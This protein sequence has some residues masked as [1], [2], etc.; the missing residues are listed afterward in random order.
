MNPTTNTEAGAVADV[1]AIARGLTIRPTLALTRWPDGQS[2]TWMA[3]CQLAREP[4][5][6]LN[7]A[8]KRVVQP[9]VDRGLAYMVEPGSYN[10]ETRDW[11]DKL[12]ALTPSGLAV[13]QHLTS[14]GATAS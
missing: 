4:G 9:L 6:R 5:D 12:Y 10:P 13:R 1:A 11:T 3:V 8:F 14:Q 7:M 2:L